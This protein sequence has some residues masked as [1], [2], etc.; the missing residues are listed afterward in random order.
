MTV[1][2][3]DEALD[4][5]ELINAAGSETDGTACAMTALSWVA[6]EAWTDRPQCASRLLTNWVINANDDTGTTVEQRKE[7][8]RQG[9]TGI[10]DTW[11]IPDLVMV[12]LWRQAQGATTDAITYHPVTLIYPGGEDIS[13]MEATDCVLVSETLEQI[14]IGGGG[15][16]HNTYL[17][18]S[19][20]DLVVALT[21][22]KDLC[23]DAIDVV[24]DAR[25]DR[26]D[27]DRH[28]CPGGCLTRLEA[29]EVTCGKDAC[30]RRYLMDAS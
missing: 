9:E 20:P 16:L 5:F 15:V 11:W 4:R 21:A 22:I 10:I 13:D 18:L 30:E 23:S 26:A 14:D 29:D 25:Q 6:G 17:R 1:H 8:V 27:L 24:L 7:L 12:D 19:A 28:D 2:S 3:V